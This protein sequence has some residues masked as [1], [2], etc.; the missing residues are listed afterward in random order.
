CNPIPLEYKFDGKEIIISLKEIEKGASFFS[1]VVE[2]MVTDPVSREK[3][4]NNSKFRYL[5]YGRTY[6]FEDAKNQAEFEA[7]PEKFVDTNGVLKELK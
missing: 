3:I 5:Y 7:N 6:F 2:K 4:K 1:E